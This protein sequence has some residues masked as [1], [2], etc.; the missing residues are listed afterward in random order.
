MC[1]FKLLAAVIKQIDGYRRYCLWRGSDIN[2]KKPLL[3]AWKK[4]LRPKLRGDLGVI[5]LRTQNEALLLK[6]LHKFFNKADLPWV[7]MVWNKY[8]SNGK[9]PS[10]KKKGSFWWRR[11]LNLL[12]TYKGIAQA[13]SANGRSVLFWQDTWNGRVLNL[14]YP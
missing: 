3:A 14:E 13:I 4:V 5:N 6:Y 2:G 11:I 12:T 9:L 10:A 8:Y 7:K 1:T